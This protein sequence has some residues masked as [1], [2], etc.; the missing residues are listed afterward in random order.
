MSEIRDAEKYAVD[1]PT[2]PTC[3]KWASVVGHTTH[4]SLPRMRAVSADA[5]ARCDGLKAEVERLTAENAALKRREKNRWESAA[6][7]FGLP[8]D[9]S[10]RPA[11]RNG[12]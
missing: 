9:D 1:W 10:P 4:D 7:A 12:E 3:G 2:C 6:K 11:D 5:L 8:V